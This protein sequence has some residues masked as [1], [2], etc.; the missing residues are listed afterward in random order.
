MVLHICKLDKFTVPFIHFVGAQFDLEKHF[1]LTYGDSKQISGI[2]GLHFYNIEKIADLFSMVTGGLMFFVNFVLLTKVAEK[3]IFHS[4]FN[5]VLYYLLAF[6]PSLLRKSFWV[7]WGG[8]L[9]L[10]KIA[11]KSFV[12]NLNELFRR[13]VF[14]RL[15][16]LISE[17]DGDIKLA[18]QW[19]K[20]N[21]IHHESFVY[22]SNFFNNLP[23]AQ[24]SKKNREICIQI[25]NSADPSNNHIEVLEKILPFK[26]ENIKIFVPLSYGDKDYARNLI[27]KGIQMFGEKFIPLTDFMDLPNYIKFLG[28]IDIAI[29][30][31]KRQQG[32]GNIISLLGMGKKVY[33]REE[34]STRE[35]F[36]KLAIKVYSLQAFNLVPNDLSVG[37]RNQKII[38]RH[39]SQECLRKQLGN[40]FSTT[41]CKKIDKI[42]I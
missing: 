5:S 21:G 24:N 8:D 40:I 3:V 41:S 14:R 23:L 11:R 1:F 33:L 7:I 31:H 18:R 37:E 32:L 22:P 9:Y 42:K 29:F 2:S 13:I 20:C 35:F 12:S 36:N 34:V 38:E 19:Y 16:H 28:S 26:E 4:F 30:N 25:G 39:F 17:V 6:Q 10:Y 27:A 15:G